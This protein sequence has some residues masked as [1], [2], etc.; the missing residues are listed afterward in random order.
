MS[1]TRATLETPADSSEPR[2]LASFLGTVGLLM[3]VLLAFTLVAKLKGALED[4]VATRLRVAAQLALRAADEVE[5]PSAADPAFVA[6]L[7]E[8][9]RL[10]LVTTLAL[11]DP[12]GRVLVVASRP[13]A[14]ESLPRQ[15]RV[16]SR[17]A[18]AADL[19]SR[20]PDLD[21]GGG[22]SLVAPGRERS[23]VGAVLVRLDPNDLGALA[24]ARVLF[25]VG[26][27]AAAV[28]AIVGVLMLLRWANPSSP[29]GAL[30]RPAAQ[31]ASD[32]DLVLGTMK[33]AMQSLKDSETEY[34]E[35][36]N[37]AERDAEHFRTTSASIVESI[38]SGIV[39]F[40]A[41]GRITLFN[42]AAESVL[43]FDGRASKG[44]ALSE[45]FGADDPLPRLAGTLFERR[46]P[47][48][49]L[50]I[51][52]P[53]RDGAARWIGVSSSVLPRK[54]GV[55][56]GGIFL[57][58]D[59]TLAKR[60]RDEGEL[61]DRLSAVG[62]MSA[63]IAHEIKNSLHSLLGF[64]NLLREDSKGGEL[65]L[66]VR[67]ILEEMRSLEAMVKRILEFSKPSSLSRESVSLNRLAEEAASA[68]AEKARAAGVAVA[69]DLAP[70]LPA[71]WADALAVRGAFV[72][73]AANAIEAMEGA[74]AGA[75]PA[76]GGTAEIAATCGT[77][78]IATR[79][80]D[81]LGGEL[82]V[83]FRDTGP[84]IPA[85]DREK[86]FTP[87]F[88]TKRTGIGLGLALVQ[89]TIADHGGRI[90]VHSRAGIGT[91]FVVALPSADAAANAL[92]PRSGAE[93][94]T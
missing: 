42:R 37:A 74:R 69:L 33:E 12:R 47:A 1:R 40:D 32:V 9:R 83:S 26:K 31:P 13:G 3:L 7:E 35:M 44:R 28:V 85:P 36:W 29:R 39:A 92:H 24:T 4:E 71:A 75:S 73:L 72:N 58:T 25:H 65:P 61:R 53:G 87:F 46:A 38:T 52:R 21:A 10:A 55:P 18:G 30:A 84:G 34:K 45:V 77:L 22:W 67:G 51:E 43:A 88:S 93:A 49:R 17:G 19:A 6:R 20:A 90:Q 80:A 63:G 16:V 54:D 57:V 66:P 5:A 64:A 91:E 27:I 76:A 60:A 11:Y 94:S 89:K 82:R 15:V 23:G 50:E 79:A 81:S 86:V 59:L 78:T 56:A 2:G 68:V 41:S 62:E 70:E 48:S 8:A 14:D